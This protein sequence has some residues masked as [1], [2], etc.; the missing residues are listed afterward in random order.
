MQVYATNLLSLTFVQSPNGNIKL[1]GRDAAYFL[2]TGAPSAALDF[3]CK[4]LITTPGDEQFINQFYW[5][6]LYR[7]IVRVVLC[8]DMFDFSDTV[9]VD[10]CT[11]QNLSWREAL[12]RAVSSSLADEAA[13]FLYKTAD[14]YIRIKA[15][16]HVITVTFNE[17]ALVNADVED[18][19]SFALFDC[20]FIEDLRGTYCLPDEVQPTLGLN[21]C[22][23]DTLKKWVKLN[24]HSLCQ[25]DFD[26]LK[27]THIVV[28]TDLDLRNRKFIRTSSDTEVDFAGVLVDALAFN[29]SGY[30]TYKSDGD[31]IVVDSSIRKD[32]RYIVFTCRGAHA[33]I[34]GTIQK[35]EFNPPSADRAVT[36]LS[37]MSHTLLY[38]SV[39][40]MVGSVLIGIAS[41]NPA[42]AAITTLILLGVL[43][44]S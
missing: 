10:V 5:E 12:S 7:T 6:Q 9:L 26:M 37:V 39:A 21:P 42:L 8:D 3:V 40:V 36:L 28:P 25:D 44:R 27:S 4:H 31:T 34:G 19:V 17:L 13:T 20:I 41:V 23:T 29:E 11:H 43:G 14:K 32:G 24:N 15:V 2:C 22:C 16:N 33:N 30:N 18:N 35:L 38:G 1:L